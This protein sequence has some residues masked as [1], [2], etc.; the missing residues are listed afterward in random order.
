MAAYEVKVSSAGEVVFQGDGADIDRLE[1]VIKWHARQTD[2]GT[3][4]LVREETEYLAG[5]FRIEIQ[6]ANPAAAANFVCAIDREFR[7]SGCFR[8][9]RRWVRGQTWGWLVRHL[10][11]KEWLHPDLPHS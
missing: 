2:T 8:C 10:P 7:E 1:A 3:E 4:I 6:P 9:F 5:C 11:G